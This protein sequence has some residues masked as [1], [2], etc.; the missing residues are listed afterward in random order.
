MLHA[1][2][3]VGRHCLVD[4]PRLG[5]CSASISAMKSVRLRWAGDCCGRRSCPIVLLQVPL[6]VVTGHTVVSGG[7][8][9]A[10]GDA[11][12]ERVGRPGLEI[13]RPQTSISSVS[14]VKT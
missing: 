3:Q 1:E 2:L 13:G 9:Q 11:G 7:S 12:V 14:P 6:V 8:E 5:R 4:A 10:F